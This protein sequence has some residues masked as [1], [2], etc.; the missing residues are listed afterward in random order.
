MVGL[1]KRLFYTAI[2]VNNVVMR[3][4]LIDDKT[5]MLDWDWEKNNLDGLNP[6]KLS[7]GSNRTA[8]WKCHV[9][10]NEFT[11]RIERKT[12]GSQC[13][14]CLARKYATAK[15]EQSLAA[16]YPNIAKDWD[17]IK[18]DTTPGKVFPHSNLFF[19]WKCEKGHEW[20]DSVAH[21][22]ARQSMCPICS[23]KKILLGC[24][25]LETKF[26]YLMK[27]W[28][29][30]ENE[31]E[32]IYPNQL[33]YGSEIKAHWICERGHK[34]TKEIYRRTINKELCPECAKELRISFPE[35]AVAYYIS[36]L[37]NDAIENYRDKQ[38]NQSEIDIY[39]PSLKVGI[40]YDGD[41]WHKNVDKDIKKDNL[42]DSFGI[43]LFRIREDKCVRYESN[44]IKYYVKKRKYDEL[45]A[46]IKS[47]IERINELFSL[48]L[49]INIDIEKDS[50]SILAAVYSIKK[51]NS[52]CNTDYFADWNYDKN[53]GIDPSTIPLFSNQDF[54]WQCHKCGYEWKRNPAHRSRGRGCP[55]CANQVVIK[56]KNDLLSRF[57][58]IAKEWDYSKNKKKPDEINCKTNKQ[59]WFVCSK[60]GYSW[61]T[62]V[63]IRTIQGCGCPE[64]KKEII[65]EKVGT[66]VV[67]LDTNTVYKTIKEAGR[68]LGIHPGSISS[69]CRGIT[70]TAGGYRWAY[71][72]KK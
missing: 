43:T 41:N 62:K 66:K 15:P 29:S 26:S 58:Y 36:L 48:D 18:N 52:I 38:L 51:E 19:D 64:C 16:L 6:S 35:K 44:S 13:K 27:E 37:F 40:E 65:A 59:Y 63:S 55:C 28:D 47:V 10:G 39:I 61:L 8:H 22:V 2:I 17:Y 56:G 71:Y 69:V 12:N 14:K 7:T 23:G 50:S 33:S 67:N 45:G 60:C 25:D 20:N 9:C 30:K 4:L 49:A 1:K 5:N 32:K 42:C 70:R 34:Y 24:N 53:K 21:R 11:T 54:W 31:K 72:K 57:P 3:K 46:A 68:K